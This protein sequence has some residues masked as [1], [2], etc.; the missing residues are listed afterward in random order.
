MGPDITKI[1]P[2]VVALDLQNPMSMSI[3]HYAINTV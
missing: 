1:N 3:K 2:S